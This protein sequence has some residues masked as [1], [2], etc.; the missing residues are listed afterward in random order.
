VALA[1]NKRHIVHNL[2]HS[3][4]DNKSCQRASVMFRAF[5]FDTEKTIQAV[6]FL[7]RREHSCRMNY[8]R[9]LKVLYIAERECLA[10]TGK[11]LTGSPAYAMERGPVLE[12]VYALIKGGHRDDDL[13]NR[14]FRREHYRLAMTNDPGGSRLSKFLVGKLEEVAARHEDDDEW[15]M[16][17]ITHRL[18]EWQKNE[19]G[20]S[21][22]PIPL[23]DILAGIGRLD[24]MGAILEGTRA[25]QRSSDFF[26]SR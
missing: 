22:K 16:V 2:T 1:A 20:K 19:P 14:H 15:A 13:W 5:R 23:E 21:S 7:L 9:L 10:E 4:L 6:A 17:D 12:D 25:D 3:R 24:D 18:P 8:M 11:P 26:S